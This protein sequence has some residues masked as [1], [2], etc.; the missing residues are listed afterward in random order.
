MHVR[1]HIH[2]HE[3]KVVPAAVTD[4]LILSRF[5]PRIAGRRLR[6]GQG[7]AEWRRTSKGDDESEEPHGTTVR[8]FQSPLQKS[9]GLSFHATSGGIGVEEVVGGIGYKR[10]MADVI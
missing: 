7:R 6:S 5:G 3:N 2:H 10:L 9:Y 8:F 4:L 1:A